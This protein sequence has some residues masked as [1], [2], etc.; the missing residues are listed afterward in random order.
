VL[1]TRILAQPLMQRRLLPVMGAPRTPLVDGPGGWYVPQTTAEFEARGLAVPDYLW[2][3]Q[4]TSGNLINSI[5]SFLSLDGNAT[6][7][8]YQQSV[9]GWTRKFVGTDD[10]TAGQ[11]WATTSALLDLAAGES[12]AMVGLASF[13]ASAAS[14]RS[15]ML[16]AATSNLGLLLTAPGGLIRPSCGGGAT[17]GAIDHSD[18]ATVRQFCVYRNAST[19]V[20][21]AVT[22]LESRTTTHNEDALSGQLKGLFGGATGPAAR[23]G[24]FAIFKGANA[25]RD[26]AAYLA[27]MRG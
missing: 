25:E 17:S 14:T 2:T 13:A 23:Y 16:W 26:W 8:L 10:T 4:E 19:N 21:G 27:A 1:D 6:G 15:M 22:N 12:I 3:C 18:I 24:W 7:R 5:G 20:S 9:T 11:R